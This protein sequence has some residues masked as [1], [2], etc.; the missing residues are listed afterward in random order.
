MHVENNRE[1]IE[2]KQ[3]S[4]ED[5]FQEKYEKIDKFAFNVSNINKIIAI[6]LVFFIFMCFVYGVK[7][8]DKLNYE[9]YVYENMLTELK[10]KQL[11]DMYTNL[12]HDEGQSENTKINEKPIFNNA[13]QAVIAAFNKLYNYSAYEIEG[14]GVTNAVAVGQN[15][16]IRINFKNVMFLD[17]VQLDETVRFETQT[18]FGQ[19]EAAQYAYKNGQRYR[20][21]GG[22]IRYSNGKYIADFGGSF[23][24]YNS[25]IKSHPFYLVNSDTVTY[26]KIFSFTRKSN[27]RIAYYK[28]TVFLN[29]QTAVVDYARDIQE[30]G[31][32][33]YPSFSTLEIA[34]IIDPNGDLMSY[35]V[36]EKMT[37]TKHIVF[38]ITTT[39]TNVMTSV[40]ISHD[41]EPTM[42]KPNLT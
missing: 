37:L 21:F 27:G 18:D 7:K 11:Y 15:V 4:L 36:T 31:G 13:K 1:I 6:M 30:Q 39:T 9:Y 22:N 14:S 3:K 2:Y 20:R 24:R 19:S 10:N 33:S 5:R 25:V 28:A 12:E 17:G 38:D 41:V 40:F 26:D 34:C 32:T 16:E 8:N 29:P 42:Q 23:S 35:S